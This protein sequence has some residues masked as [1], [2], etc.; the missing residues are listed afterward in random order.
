MVQIPIKIYV[1]NLAKKAQEAA[2]PFALVANGK[3]TE[4]LFEMAEQLDT[5]T[6]EI[7]EANS[8]DLEAIPKDLGA[9]AY[10]QALDRAKITE[11][12]VH[13][14]GEGIQAIA[15][16][17]DSIGEVTHVWN[18]DD[19]MQVRRVRVP[20]G[21]IAVISEFGP[22]VTAE[23]IAM[24]LKTGNVCIF[25]GGR[26]WFY[27]NMAV[28][29]VLRETATK[30][31]I[32]EAAITFLDR[33]D[34]E[35]AL[36]LVRLPKYVNAIIPRGKGGLRKA[37]MEQ[38]RVPVLGY[39]GGPCHVYIDGDVELPLAQ[40]IVV[41][42]KIQD[43]LASNA[44]DTILVHQAASRQLLPGLL[45]R[46]LEEFKVDLCGCPKTISLMGVMEMTGHKGIKNASE[47]DWG[48]K[49]QSLTLAIKIVKDMDEGIAHIAKYGP[50]HTDAIVTRDYA[51]AMRFVREVDSSAVMV[52]ASTRLHGGPPFGLGS[53]I[54]MNT[55]HFHARGPLTLQAL[56]VEKYVAFGS[57][58]LRQPHPVPQAYED[59]M[60]M[61][62]KF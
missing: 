22:L 42:S 5:R 61:S 27:T 8:K 62:V 44:A 48:Q 14:I 25:R 29:G 16:Q 21:V 39:D 37:V 41:N 30:G 26:E 52:N 9:E 53:E 3:R 33:P 19:G 36:E 38:S 1:Q 45:R 13:E 50:G 2:R 32:P 58:H 18:T 6:E 49:Y 28:I 12:Q 43:P 23:S 11:E 60:M 56:T 7:L 10:R 35:G 47:E 59:A 54:G 34:P 24:C 31:G 40:S 17:P 46:L 4:V 15:E 20:L 57:G 55:T 51:T